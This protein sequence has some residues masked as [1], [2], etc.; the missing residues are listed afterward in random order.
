MHSIKHY[1]YFMLATCLLLLAG[2]GFHLRMAHPLPPSLQKLYLDSDAPYGDFSLELQQML[3]SINVTLVNEPTAAPI[4]LKVFS[5]NFNST[6]LSES[7]SS[8]TK[9][10]VLHFTM[11]YEL[12]DAHGNVI[13][14]PKTIQNERNYTVN[15]NQVLSTDSDQAALRTEME[16]DAVF[17]ILMQLDSPEV[18]NAVTVQTENKPTPQT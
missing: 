1:I 11:Q 10:Y 2:C 16:R 4:T 3:K 7:A 8:T 5:E 15:E 12:L 9:Q 6:V 13:W 14:G 17:M 18:A